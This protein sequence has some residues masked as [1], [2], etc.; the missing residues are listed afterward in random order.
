[1]CKRAIVENYICELL[2]SRALIDV[3]PLSKANKNT[4]KSRKWIR[5]TNCDA[6][7]YSLNT[8]SF[9]HVYVNTDYIHT[10]MHIGT[11]ES[12][13]RSSKVQLKLRSLAPWVQPRS[14]TVKYSSSSIS[15]LGF[16]W[17]MLNLGGL[18]A[19]T[20]VGGEI[21]SWGTSAA[22]KASWG[23]CSLKRPMSASQS[24]SPSPSCSFCT[25]KKQEVIEIWKT[26]V[27]PTVPTSILFFI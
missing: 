9:M 11:Y 26:K 5:R 21:G 14:G 7:L 3:I 18:Y 10:Q 6:T 1:M 23:S 20:L 4:G 22:A 19:F 13:R 12:M 2:Q 8:R 25:E 24:N 27:N 16:L 17:D 15:I